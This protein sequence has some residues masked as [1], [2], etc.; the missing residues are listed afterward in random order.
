MQSILATPE[1]ENILGTCSISPSPRKKIDTT[2]AGIPLLQKGAINVFINMP[3]PLKVATRN[4]LEQFITAY[5]EVSRVP[6][7]SPSL[8]DGK[9]KDIEGQLKSAQSEDEIPEILVASGLHTVFSEAFRKRFIDT[10][11]YVP[12]IPDEALSKLTDT[13]RHLVLDKNI[14]I[15]GTGFWNLVCDLSVETTV[16]YPK[17]WTDLVNPIYR[18]QISVH[19]YNGKASIAAL[20]LLLRERLGNQAI[21]DFGQNIRNIWHFAEIL[22]RLDTDEPRRTPFNLLPNAASVQMPSKKRGAIF[23]FQEGPVLA[24][25]LMYVKASKAELCKPFV[26]FFFS[27]VMRKNLRRGDF[28]LA[29]DFDWKREFCFPDW[30]Y[31]VKND[32][33]QIS[34]SLN[35]ELKKGLRPDAFTM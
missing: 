10:R 17:Q 12:A 7:Y 13:Y 1:N 14:G 6:I 20:L 26:H 35:A 15:V 24:P 25:M 4:C 8:Q 21:T 32:Y 18:D 3:C 5:N 27:E 9:T 19:G 22:K 31:L 23:E 33:E 2:D 28:Y 34:E 11:I 29:D 30:N 16:P